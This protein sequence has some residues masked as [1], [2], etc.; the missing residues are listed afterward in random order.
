M[1]DVSYVIYQRNDNSAGTVLLW[2]G[3]EDAANPRAAV[4]AWYKTASEEVQD[5]IEGETLV[6][7]PERNHHELEPRIETQP[8][9][10]F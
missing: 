8:R 9:L 2:L 7:I 5:S 6:V 3:R 10:A 4:R 1:P